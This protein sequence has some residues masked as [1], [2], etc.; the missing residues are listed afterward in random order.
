MFLYT[1]QSI[2]TSDFVAMQVK[3]NIKIFSKKTLTMGAHGSIIK[4][5]LRAT[6]KSRKRRPPRE[7]K[8][9]EYEEEEDGY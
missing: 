2:A 7:W 9:D 5:Q 4:S 8:C 1:S 3:A 6:Q